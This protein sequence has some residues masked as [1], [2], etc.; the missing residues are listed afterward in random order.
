MCAARSVFATH[1]LAARSGAPGSL[2]SGLAYAGVAPNGFDTV[3]AGGRR[4]PIRG[5]AFVIRGVPIGDPITLSGPAGKRTIAVEA[6]SSGTLAFVHVRSE[7]ARSDRRRR[8]DSYTI[9][10]LLAPGYTAVSVDGKSVRVVEGRFGMPDVRPRPF[11]L[12]RVEATGPDGTG[13]LDLFFGPR[14]S[15]VVLR[16]YRRR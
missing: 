12:L 2:S 1:F 9:S 7:P 6:H 15:R 4:A 8:P 5:N 10:G 14:F 13:F 16:P 11:E 3:E